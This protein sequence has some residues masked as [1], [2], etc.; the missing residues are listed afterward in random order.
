[1][2]PGLQRTW[3]RSISSFLVPLREHATLSPAGLRQQLA[4]HLDAG[5]DGLG[6]GAQADDLDFLADLD[7]AGAL[8]TAVATVPRREMEKT[9]STRHQE[10]LF[11]LADGLGM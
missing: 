3:P 10:G 11:D 2:V 8:D 7:L 6:G 4:E 1:M 5:D 9:S